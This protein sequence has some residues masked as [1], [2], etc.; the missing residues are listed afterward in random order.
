VNPLLT[1]SRQI[2]AMLRFILPAV[3]LAAAV[4]SAP[5]GAA[6]KN[7]GVYAFLNVRDAAACQRA[8]ADDGLCMAWALYANSCELSAVVPVSAPTEATASAL[9]ARAPAFASLRPATTAPAQIAAAPLA[10]RTAPTDEP[11]V[12]EISAADAIEPEQSG[13]AG[14]VLL[15]GP[16]DGDLR[17]SRN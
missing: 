9:A 8:C 11:D 13:D 14:L 3:V 7:P 4:L 16:E 17:I 15:G 5:A 10:A 1:I 12:F 6:D 2:R